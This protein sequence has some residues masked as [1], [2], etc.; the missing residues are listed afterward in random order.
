M[1]HVYGGNLE[2]W[3]PDSAEPSC[4]PWEGSRRKEGPACPL[5]VHTVRVGVK[6]SSGTS[7]GFLMTDFPQRTPATG[8]WPPGS[9][10]SAHCG[11]SI[12]P[13]SEFRGILLPLFSPPLLRATTSRAALPQQASFPKKLGLVPLET[14]NWAEPMRWHPGAWLDS[15]ATALPFPGWVAPGITSPC[16][17]ALF[18]TR[19]R[20]GCLA[21]LLWVECS[22]VCKAQS[23]S[24]WHQAELAEAEDVGFRGHVWHAP[25]CPLLRNEWLEEGN[26]GQR[27]GHSSFP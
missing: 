10:H 7:R 8:P 26:R 1:S 13:H 25:E 5:S 6:R 12:R 16:F 4:V 23:D 11:S 24:C 20:V 2:D 17:I 3:C 18:V 21:A 22:P 9:F 14:S 27:L 15:C 19:G